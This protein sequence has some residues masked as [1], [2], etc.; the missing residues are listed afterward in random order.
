MATGGARPEPKGAAISISN[1][2]GNCAP[3]ELTLKV[4]L[5]LPAVTLNVPPAWENLRPSTL[6]CETS[7]S[8][9][10]ENR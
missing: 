4:P 2:T 3:S 5:P 8:W 6:H 1:G 9:S 7:L 10:D